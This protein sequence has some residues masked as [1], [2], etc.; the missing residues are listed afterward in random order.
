M[1]VTPISSPH[2]AA[3]PTTAPVPARTQAAANSNDHASKPAKSSSA[4]PGTGLKVDKHA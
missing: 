2:V 4:A 1:S 3:K